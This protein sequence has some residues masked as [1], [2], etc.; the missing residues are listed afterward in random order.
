MNN[1][2]W[3]FGSIPPLSCCPDTRWGKA[4]E[5]WISVRVGWRT[6][7][8]PKVPAPLPMSPWKQPPEQEWMEH[9]AIYKVLGLHNDLG[10]WV[11]WPS[12]LEAEECRGCKVL[13]CHSSN[14]SSVSFWLYEV[15]TVTKPLSALASS[16]EKLHNNSDG[17]IY[18]VGMLKD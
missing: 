6:Q 12:S 14:Y 2:S 11:L 8:N 15:R 9:S 16:Y 10:R 17:S 4:T 5:K 13:S 3:R 1:K 7:V 18:F